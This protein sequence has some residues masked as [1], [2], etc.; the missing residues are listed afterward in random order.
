MYK[1][2]LL[3]PMLVATLGLAESAQAG[4]VMTYEA[5]VTNDFGAADP[6]GLDGSH[7]KVA[8][9]FADGQQYG[10]YGFGP[11]VL[12]VAQ[13]AT[14]TV[15]GAS[16]ALSNGTFAA[17]S[18]AGVGLIPPDLISRPARFYAGLDTD[19]GNRPMVFGLPLVN[20][21]FSIQAEP[22]PDPIPLVGDV[23]QGSDFPTSGLFSSFSNQSSI[24]GGSEPIGVFSLSNET[25]NLSAVPVPASLML[26][27]SGLVL[28]LRRR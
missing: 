25:L 5:D 4:L 20:M 10:L 21:I 14:I 11:D 26:G 8:L 15:S 19:P 9:T 17:I 18:G 27:V 22:A 2:R 23:I 12:A 6:G 16:Q 1:T 24:Y 7:I 28:I 3:L 13:S